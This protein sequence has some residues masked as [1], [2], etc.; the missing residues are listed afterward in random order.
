MRYFEFDF[1]L[2]DI[3]TFVYLFLNLFYAGMVKPSQNC[4]EAKEE[5][6]IEKIL[7]DALDR[8]EIIPKITKDRANRNFIIIK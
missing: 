7:K 4:D 8:E 6:W 5:Q 2:H 3:Y 1:E